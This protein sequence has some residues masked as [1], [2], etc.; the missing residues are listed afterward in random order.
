MIGIVACGSSACPAPSADLGEILFI[1]KYQSQGEID[2]TLNSFETFSLTV[3]SDISGSA[4]IQ[5]QQ[6]FLLT[7]PVSLF[8]TF[9][10]TFLTLLQR[11]TR[12]LTSSTPALRLRSLQALQAL[13]STSTPTVITLNVWAF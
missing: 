13:R 1:G 5:V 7:P 10:T 4:S 2:N 11:D 12:S 9:R 3:P 6:V 8:T